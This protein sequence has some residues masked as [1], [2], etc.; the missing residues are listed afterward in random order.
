MLVLSRMRDEVIKIGE[1]IEIIVVEVRDG[2]VRLGISAPKDIPV[3]R[4]EVYE[5]IHR[6]P[7]DVGREGL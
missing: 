1:D 7:A 2:K 4:L 6:Q 3:H 5:Q